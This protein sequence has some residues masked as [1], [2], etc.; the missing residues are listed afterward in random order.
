MASQSSRPHFSGPASRPGGT[1]WSP[2]APAAESEEAPPPLPREEDSVD[3]EVGGLGLLLLSSTEV[4]SSTPFFLLLLLPI[5]LLV[6]LQKLADSTSSV[7]CENLKNPLALKMIKGHPSH[8][9]E[10]T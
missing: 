9:T 10:R 2:G 3:E 6:L 1:G 7:S 8:D 4:G 5:L